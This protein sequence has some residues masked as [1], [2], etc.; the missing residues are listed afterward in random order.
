MVKEKGERNLAWRP[1]P[2]CVCVCVCVV[3]LGDGMRVK[4]MLMRER[5]EGKCGRALLLGVV[6]LL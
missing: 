5:E 3:V 1:G 4:V 2:V 6:N